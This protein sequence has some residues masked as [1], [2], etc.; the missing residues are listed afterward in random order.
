MLLLEWNA[1]LCGLLC[2]ANNLDVLSNVA[3]VGRSADI[4]EDELA[5]GA[6]DTIDATS[7]GDLLRLVGLSRL[8][9]VE[10]LEELGVV[11]VGLEL[12]RV[13]VVVGIA[14]LEKGLDLPRPDLVVLVGVELLLLSSLGLGLSL[15]RS[16]GSL[17]SLLLLILTRLHALLEFRLGDLRTI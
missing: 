16:S 14:R 6:A 8:E 13:W 3:G 12:V 9:V 7:H 1:T 15:G 10:L 11:I 17:S 2:L 4:V 5:A